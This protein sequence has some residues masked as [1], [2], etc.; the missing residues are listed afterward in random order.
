MP[1][2]V[3][4]G[5][6]IGGVCCVEELCRLCPTDQVTLISASTVLKV[7]QAANEGGRGGRPGRCPSDPP[8]LPH[9]HY[10]LLVHTTYTP[11]AWAMWCA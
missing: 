5:G 10:T 4:I 7:S 1:R 6:G 3:V 9:T 8:P 2:Y 11:R